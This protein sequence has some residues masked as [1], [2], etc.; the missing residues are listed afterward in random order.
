MILILINENLKARIQTCRSEIRLDSI[1]LRIVT[2]PYQPS[3]ARLSSLIMNWRSTS[4]RFRI[5][6]IGL[7][8]L[9]P[10]LLASVH[11]YMVPRVLFRKML[12]PVRRGRRGT[13]PPERSVVRVRGV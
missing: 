7:Q 6:V 10:L 11:A 2:D 4:D 3:F 1:C 5:A 9:R 13:A 8:W 12:T